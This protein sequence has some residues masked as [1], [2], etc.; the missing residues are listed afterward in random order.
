MG[1]FS[2]S[3]RA[4]SVDDDRREKTEDRREKGK[5]SCCGCGCH[6]RAFGLFGLALM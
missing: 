4:L 3:F 1:E 5:G 2:R 6:D